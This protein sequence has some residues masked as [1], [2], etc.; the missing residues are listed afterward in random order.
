MGIVEDYITNIEGTCGKEK[1]V[2]VTF[3]YAKRE[4]VLTKILKKAKIRS[5]LSGVIFDLIFR[6]YS[7]RLFSTGKAIFSDVPSKEE[8]RSILSDLLQ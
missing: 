7:F 6:G 1:T 4:E 5:S 3:K 2:I 8:L